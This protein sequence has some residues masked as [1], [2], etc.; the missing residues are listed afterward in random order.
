MREQAKIM[1]F[2]ISN[3]TYEDLENMFFHYTWNSNY[4]SINENG[5]HASVGPNSRGLDKKQ[6]IFFQ[7]DWKLYCKHGMFG[8]NGDLID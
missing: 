6:S 5:L 4:N 7:K 2:N 8:L 3:L 1:K